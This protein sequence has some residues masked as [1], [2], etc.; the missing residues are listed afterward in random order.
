MASPQLA[1]TVY[2]QDPETHQTVELAPGTCP[3]PHLAALVTNPLAWVDGKMPRLKISPAPKDPDPVTEQGPGGTPEGDSPNGDGRDGASGASSDTAAD[4]SPA[5]PDNGVAPAA[6]DASAGAVATEP[7]AKPATETAASD[8][9][10]KSTKPAAK[11][12]AARPARGRAD[13]AE[14]NGAQ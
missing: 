6:P 3:P 4:G 2:V 9:D 1:A 12:A 10:T 11:K 13:A 14:G 7:E 8:G 5:E